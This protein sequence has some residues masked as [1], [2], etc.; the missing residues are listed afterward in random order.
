MHPVSNTLADTFHVASVSLICRIY[1]DLSL[2]LSRSPVFKPPVGAAETFLLEN[3]IYKNTYFIL[4]ADTLPN[5]IKWY[6]LYVPWVLLAVAPDPVGICL[7]VG[8]FKNQSVD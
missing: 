8:S 3:R 6:N 2:K 1:V 4:W 7:A 5:I